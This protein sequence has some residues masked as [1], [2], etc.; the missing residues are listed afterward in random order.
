MTKRR[1]RP[2]FAVTSFINPHDICFAHRARVNGKSRVIDLYNEAKALSES[3]LPPLPENFPITEGEPAFLADNLST[4][5][6]TPPGIM[7]RDYTERDWR[8]YRWVYRRLTERVDREISVMLEGLKKAGL[9]ENTLIVFTSDHGDMDAAHRLASKNRFYEESVG[10]PLLMTYR[11]VIPAGKVDAEHLVSTGL[12]ILP[13]LCDYAGIHAPAHLLGRSLRPPAEGRAVSDWRTY[14]ASEIG[15]RR[16]IRSRRHKYCSYGDADTTEML[17]DL[18][19]DPG[20]MKNL[21]S[22]AG[23][24][25][26]LLRHRELLERWSDLSRDTQAPEDVRGA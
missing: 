10:V 26:T 4:T 9:E 5:A 17:F 23:H 11:G 12:D 16:M 20:E 1:D 19:A 22:E 14:V 13:T 3:E 2:F 8:I 21:A 25:E 18:E 7:R 6:V 15:T 24:R